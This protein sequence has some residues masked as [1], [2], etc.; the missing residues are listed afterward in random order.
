MLSTALG[1]LIAP[2]ANDTEQTILLF[3]FSFLFIFMIFPVVLGMSTVYWRKVGSTNTSC[4]FA[5][6][7]YALHIE[8]C[9]LVIAFM[10]IADT[11][12]SSGRAQVAPKRGDMTFSI[13]YTQSGSKWVG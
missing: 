13:W 1:I 5:L 2:C 9:H 8:K 11:E 4:P 12:R 6:V 10:S 3:E 7:L